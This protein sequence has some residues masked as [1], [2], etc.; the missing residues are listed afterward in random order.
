MDTYKGF[1][2]PIHYKATTFN[3]RES[4]VWTEQIL[5]SNRDVF[6]T[7]LVNVLHT[8][9][10]HYK[11]SF[12][13][14]N[15]DENQLTERRREQGKI[16]KAFYSMQNDIHNL[17]VLID[18][19][20][21]ASKIRFKRW[22]YSDVIV[23]NYI[24]NIR[25]IYDFTVLLMRTAL[26]DKQRKDL[27]KDV[28]TISGL[29]KKLKNNKKLISYKFI[30]VLNKHD[31]NFQWVRSIRDRLIHDGDELT[32]N[33]DDNDKAMIVV[34]KLNKIEDEADNE[35]IKQELDLMMVLRDITNNLFDYLDDL[36][37][38]IYEILSENRE[39]PLPITYTAFEG[40][41]I[42]KFVKFLGR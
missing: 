11:D 34:Y 8:W 41:C 12:E 35:Y 37:D 14:N 31:S 38:V 22:L 4:V 5:K 39:E 13:M 1:M 15:L 32:I 33:F 6:S 18:L 2:K 25:S 40:F 29:R 10:S 9:I 27:N 42:P 20:E 24:V 3:F 36:A 30:E 26:T 23:E 16:L 28:D 21:D 17:A 19:L 7:K